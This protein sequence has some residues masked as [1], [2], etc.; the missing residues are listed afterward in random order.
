MA[1]IKIYA[2]EATLQR[3]AEPMSGVIHQCLMDA[4]AYPAEKRFQRFIP[5]RGEWFLHP[6]DRGPDYTILEFSIFEGRS[7][8]AKRKLIHS[9]FDR[10][11]A[12]LGIAPLSLEITIFETPRLNWGIRGRCGDELDLG[13]RVDV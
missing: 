10:F 3:L 8:T 2:R 9:L 7:E 12:Q 5:L 13:Y 6:E 1:Q 4:F 11:E